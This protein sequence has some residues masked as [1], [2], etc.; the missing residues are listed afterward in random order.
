MQFFSGIAPNIVFL[1][2]LLAP[3]QQDLVACIGA[4]GHQEI[5]ISS[6]GN[7]FSCL[8]ADDHDL[9]PSETTPDVDHCGDCTDIPLTILYAYVKSKTHDFYV[10]AVVQSSFERPILTAERDASD[11]TALPNPP[12]VQTVLA[13]LRTIILLI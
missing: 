9:A 2:M 4:D 11:P 7:C 8:G 12:P 1:T 13:S 6:M 5:E 3:I 10:Q